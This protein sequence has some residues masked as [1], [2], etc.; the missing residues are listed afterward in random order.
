MAQLPKDLVLQRTLAWYFCHKKRILFKFS[1][2]Y[3]VLIIKKKSLIFMQWKMHFTTTMHNPNTIC[4]FLSILSSFIIFIKNLWRHI[5][6]RSCWVPPL[7]RWRGKGNLE[8]ML[9]IMFSSRS[10]GEGF[11]C[12]PPATPPR[13]LHILGPKIKTFPT[14]RAPHCRDRNRTVLDSNPCR[15]VYKPADLG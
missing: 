12:T 1:F 13:R 2:C 8:S 11:L 3:G 7:G 10:P 6:L 5:S 9:A 14:N 4:L 15:T